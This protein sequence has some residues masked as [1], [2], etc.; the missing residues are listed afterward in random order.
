MPRS[1]TGLAGTLVV[2]L[3]MA[4]ARAGPASAQP[5]PMPDAG[6]PAPG[7]RPLSPVAL[8]THIDTTQR[9]LDDH[10]DLSQRLPDGHIDL[11]RMREGGLTGAFFSIW[12]DPRRYPGEAAWERAQALVRVVRELVTLHPEAAALC[13]T[14]DEVRAANAGGR[15]A[16]LMGVE[17]AHA[18]GD[19]PDAE[20]LARL[21]RLF[22]LGARYMTITWTNDNR[23]GHASTG[24]H[25]ERGLTSL[26]R[27]AVREMNRLG[28]IVD[29]SHVSD[30]TA[31][32]AVRLSRRPV[33]ASHSSVRSLAD[34]PRNLPDDLIREIAAR[35]G[36]V[37]V[38]YYP[39]FIDAAWAEGHRRHE[40]DGAVPEPAL[41]GLDV[42]VAHFARVAEL[43]GAGAPCMGSDFDGIGDL[44]RGLTDVTGLPGLVAALAARSLDT[45][46]IQGENVL[47]VL[48]AQR[49]AEP[50]GPARPRAPRRA[51][52]AGV[53]AGT[54][55]GAP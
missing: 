18:L 47:R 17:G 7:P 45:R 40:H 9:M 54:A 34:R 13:T 38:N 26:G 12:V 44:P 29:V 36:A 33:L 31:R 25:P 41:P 11:P 50:L 20:L 14:A 10:V 37:C 4:A 49:P 35:G 22:A 39:G 28:M 5:R 51:R 23:F 19:A 30:Q 43:G 2:V 27:R 48:A 53:P 16:V 32:D 42:L 52:A 3:A 6:A 55:P 8:D 15:V 21:R 46:A 1:G 24:A